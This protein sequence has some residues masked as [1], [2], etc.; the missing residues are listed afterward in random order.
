MV[1][2]EVP[3]FELDGLLE[4]GFGK[5]QLSQARQIG[6]QVGPGRGRIR[7]Q[8]HGRLQV[9]PGLGILRLRG[10]DQSQEFVHLKAFGHLA[11]ERLQLRR[12]LGKVAGLI[13]GHG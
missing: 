1:G 9:L 8:A 11:N 2:I 5:V 7:F 10:I 13:L 6:R 12:S 3:G 4:L